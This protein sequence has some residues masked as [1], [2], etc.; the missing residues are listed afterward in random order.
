[1][2]FFKVF[3]KQIMR[4]IDLNQYNGTYI[5]IE[6]AVFFTCETFKSVY[7]SCAGLLPSD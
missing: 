3:N 6:Q 1:M 5:S 2:Q 7:L 4:F